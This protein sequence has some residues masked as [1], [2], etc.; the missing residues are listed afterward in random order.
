MR[1]KTLMASQ[2]H[3]NRLQRTVMDK[4]PRH[5][6]QRAAA[7]PERYTSVAFVASLLT[8]CVSVADQQQRI[9]DACDIVEAGTWSLL[10]SA[11]LNRD[12]LL[13]L[14]I[15]K[16]SIREELFEGKVV[17]REA[18][19]EM[20]EDN[21]LVCAYRLRSNSCSEVGDYV[22]FTRERS[23]WSANPPTHLKVCD[24]L[25][26]RRAAASDVPNV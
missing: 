10:E 1:G 7:E 3:N 19:F 11:P 6:R 17:F 18:W 5:M 26:G 24:P 13:A 20:G 14:Q 15:G 9:A 8:A 16:D 22:S 12:E 2:A 25:I 23:R 21:L 4:V